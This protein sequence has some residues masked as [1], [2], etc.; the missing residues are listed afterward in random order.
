MLLRLILVSI[1]Q[2]EG[3]SNYGNR[4][5][6]PGHGEIEGFGTMFKT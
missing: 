2:G 1:A 4:D 6:V 5:T 3:K